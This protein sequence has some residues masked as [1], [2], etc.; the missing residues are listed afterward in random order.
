MVKRKTQFE[1][2]LWAPDRGPDW[3]GEQSNKTMETHKKKRTSPAKRRCRQRSALRDCHMPWVSTAPQA[4]SK[5]G[6]KL[7][8]VG[9]GGHGRANGFD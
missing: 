5:G 3:N 8:I 1:L 2:W 6:K 4:N 9:V 7:K